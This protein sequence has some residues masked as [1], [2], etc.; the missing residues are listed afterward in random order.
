[1]ARTHTEVPQ[2]ISISCIGL[3]HILR[4]VLTSSQYGVVV[5]RL[6]ELIRDLR[7]IMSDEKL[8]KTLGEVAGP[9]EENRV[10][11]RRETRKAVMFHIQ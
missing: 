3:L 4:H 5:G 7:S 2:V 10:T 8:S 1:M 11:P 9:A 6:L